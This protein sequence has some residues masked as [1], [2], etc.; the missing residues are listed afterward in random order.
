MRSG[1]C[2]IIF[3]GLLAGTSVASAQAVLTRA[4]LTTT[5]GGDNKDHDTCVWA[6][7]TTADGSSELAKIENGD[8]GGD[9]STEYND[10]STHTISLM[11]EA[12]GASK[13]ACRGFK[14]HLW[15]KTHGG[16][17]HDNWEVQSAKV[18]LY[19]SDGLNLK[20]ET[21]SF[22]L[23]SHSQDDAPSTDFAN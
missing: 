20:A 15:Q 22:T 21:G 19:F 23:N 1:L 2:C 11:I 6:T 16:A 5:T 9:D 13:D 7:V 12:A 4:E 14:V 8:C 10:H 17:G 3:A 18:I